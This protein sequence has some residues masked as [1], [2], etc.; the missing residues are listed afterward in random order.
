M[1]KDDGMSIDSWLRAVLDPNTHVA[2]NRCI[3]APLYGSKR[4]A[5]TTMERHLLVYV[6]SGTLHARVDD[7]RFHMRYGNIL[8]IPPG[9]KKEFWSSA[10]SSS[11]RVHLDILSDGEHLSW[12]DGGALRQDCHEAYPLFHRLHHLH[13][14]HKP[15][16]DQQVRALTTLIASIFCE[17]AEVAEV[18]GK[19]SSDRCGII[20][21]YVRE[22]MRSQITAQS[23]AKLLDMT[24]DYV[25]RL[26]TETYGMPP[27][28]FIK[29]ERLLRSAMLLEET[30]AKVKMIAHDVG[31]PNV[32]LFCRLFH[33]RFHQTPSQYREYARSTT[34]NPHAW[35]F[36]GTE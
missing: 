12:F 1:T 6:D 26:F 36:W 22:N 13:R 28:Q 4:G 5:V 10:D 35:V 18:A 8:W 14:F 11:I 21:S 17:A 16:T 9:C 31:I 19:L 32:S 29:E 33:K 3:Y 25:T 2:L 7:E 27:R 34:K 23:I 30:D 24:P 20:E 15:S